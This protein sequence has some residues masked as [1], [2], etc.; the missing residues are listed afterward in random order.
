[1]KKM[2][3]TK[4]FHVFCLVGRAGKAEGQDLIRP[5]KSAHLFPN[6]IPFKHLHLPGLSSP[7]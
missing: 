5:P 3:F 6:L 2:N 1:M 4:Y 7:A